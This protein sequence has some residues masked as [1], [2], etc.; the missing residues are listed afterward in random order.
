MTSA[1]VW[2]RC[3]CGSDAEALNRPV[4]SSVALMESISS[5]K[6]ISAA[7]LELPAL[8]AGVITPDSTALRIFPTEQR[9]SRES[10]LAEMNF[11]VFTMMLSLSNFVRCSLLVECRRFPSDH[12][13]ARGVALA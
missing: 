1:G 11:V 2:Q 10:S 9:T 12:A 4:H 8:P 3:G 5:R 13:G 7:L 6:K